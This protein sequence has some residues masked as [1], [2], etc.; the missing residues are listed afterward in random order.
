VNKQGKERGY[1]EKRAL[2]KERFLAKSKKSKS[3]EKC[4]KKDDGRRRTLKKKVPM[5]TIMSVMI[6]IINA[7]E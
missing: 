4:G 3:E 2:L 5:I 7:P 6:P 1:N